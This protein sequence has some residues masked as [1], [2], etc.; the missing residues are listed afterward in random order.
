MRPQGPVGAEPPSVVFPRARDLS[1]YVLALAMVGAG[2]LHFARPAPYVKIMPAGLPYP[3]AL[4]WLSGGFEILGG[5]G[6]LVPA[7]RR[8]A[9][10]GLIALF[11]AVF[12]ANLNMAVN[13]VTV[14]GIPHNRLLY[15]CRLP[16][17]A[18]LIGWAW[19]L[20]TDRGSSR[21]AKRIAD[22]GHDV[23]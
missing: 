21:K 15:W 9:A 4:V 3:H 8:A 19:W 16:F 11:L 10:W 22:A 5:V 17:Q 6:L 1:R 14:E 23:L 12:P 20:A 13:D 2:L 18:V 7:T